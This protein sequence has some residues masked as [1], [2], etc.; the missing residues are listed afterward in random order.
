MLPF[1]L[2][3]VVGGLLSVNEIVNIRYK[4][5]AV[6]ILS[7]PFLYL[8]AVLFGLLS[9]L[10]LY[11]IQ[12]GAISQDLVQGTEGNLYMTAFA[13]GMCTRAFFDIKL[14]NV[15]TGGDKPFSVG[16]KT[17]TQF[18]EDPLLGRI[19]SHWFK[20]YREFIKE[21]EN[22][23]ND[24]TTEEVHNKAVEGLK[25]F[26]DQARV[27]AFLSGAFASAEV[28]KDKFGLVITEFGTRVFCQIFEVEIKPG[29]KA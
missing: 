14:F 18:V 25:D 22:K 10:F 9:A 16:V 8:Y 19:D 5:I 24:K 2:A 17:I 15:P 7:S 4:K 28:K 29:K 3:F 6:F 20:H 26:P 13:V 21:V 12:S 1:A 27:L 23:Y 11:L